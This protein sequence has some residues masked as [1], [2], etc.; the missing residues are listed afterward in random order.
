V[1]P[2]FVN[3]VII[4]EK[5]NLSGACGGTATSKIHRPENK[6]CPL[7]LDKSGIAAAGG[8]SKRH[9]MRQTWNW[10]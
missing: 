1:C 8:P 2:V 7:A 5:L 10:Y 6:V 3:G 4:G 9:A